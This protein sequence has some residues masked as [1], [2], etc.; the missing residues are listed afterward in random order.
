VRFF[1][2]ESALRL[3]TSPDRAY[4]RLRLD[5]SHADVEE[6]RVARLCWKIQ[7]QETTVTTHNTKDEARME[8]NLKKKE[9]QAREA[10]KAMAE[11]QAG[12]RALVE[13][14]AR[15]RALRLAKEAA[16]AEARTA[17]KKTPSK[18]AG[19]AANRG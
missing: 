17:S 8:A 14:T 5:A 1:N 15:L 6:E 10:N 18:R 11:Y 19:V 7:R 16:D 13:N 2:K 4:I 3:E 9:L 12:R